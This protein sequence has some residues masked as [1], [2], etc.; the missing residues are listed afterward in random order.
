[1]LVVGWENWGLR[2]I[3]AVLGGPILSVDLTRIVR[4]ASNNRNCSIYIVRLGLINYYNYRTSKSQNNLNELQ[5]QRDMTIEKLKEATKYNS[6]QELLKKYGGSSPKNR[7]DETSE[8]KSSSK[9]DPAAPSRRR[10]GYVPPPTANIPGRIA[11]HSSHKSQQPTTPSYS[12]IEQP[13][14]ISTEGNRHR[15]P[16]PRQ[17]TAEAEFAPN[18][19]PAAPQYAKYKEGPRWYDRL[20]DVLLGEDEASTRNRLALI[21]RHCR[22]VNGQ[23]PPGVKRLEDVGKW[24]CAECSSMNGEE[25]EATKII[26]KISNDT[27]PQ[28]QEPLLERVAEATANKDEEADRRKGLVEQGAGDE[29]DITQYSEDFDKDEK[30]SQVEN[31]KPRHKTLES[32]PPRRRADSPQKPTD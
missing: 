25:T 18:A 23:A 14:S 3:G 12:R 9:K 31:K 7:V 30:S 19:F 8:Q 11:P 16:S 2:E 15:L 10:T 22:L 29:S 6:T 13:P 26:E 27:Q 28:V 24:R 17:G 21:C 5:K 4:T 1:M 20:I 32:N